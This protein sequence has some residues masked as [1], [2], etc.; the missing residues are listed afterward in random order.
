MSPVQKI[1]MERGRRGKV[2]EK[3]RE[4]EMERERE[5]SLERGEQ[6]RVPQ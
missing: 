3:E 6:G 4:R 1:S 5:R 2:E